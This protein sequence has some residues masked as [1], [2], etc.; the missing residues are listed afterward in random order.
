MTRRRRYLVPK[1]LMGANA[2]GPLCAGVGE[3]SVILP[4]GEPPPERRCAETA[5]F[6]NARRQRGVTCRAISV[7]RHH[8]ENQ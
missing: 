5:E 3:W 1:I 2:E 6:A 4:E 7:F 8:E